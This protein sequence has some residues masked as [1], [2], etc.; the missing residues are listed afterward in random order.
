[1]RITDTAEINMNWD[2]FTYPI[3]TGTP[4]SAYGVLSNDGDAVGIIARSVHK[5]P[6]G[7]HTAYLMTGGS[8]YLSELGYTDLSADAMQAMHGI[9]FFGSDGTPEADPVYSITAATETAIGGVKMAANVPAAAG[10]APTAA[11]FKA[12]LD[13]LKEAGIMV[14]DE[15]TGS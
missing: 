4:I 7:V 9:S 15:T 11:E 2:S 3:Q 1:M 14:A 10:S 13:A 12:L 5:K 8:V 6:D